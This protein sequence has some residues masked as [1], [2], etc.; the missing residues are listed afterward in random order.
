MFKIGW[1]FSFWSSESLLFSVCFIVFIGL[2]LK[3]LFWGWLQR[4]HATFFWA[5]FLGP[6]TLAW[7]FFTQV[8]AWSFFYATNL[9]SS[10]LRQVCV[11][12]HTFILTLTLWFLFKFHQKCWKWIL[13]S[14]KLEENQRSHPCEIWTKLKFFW[15]F[16][17][18]FIKFW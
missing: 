9:A 6:R 10:S 4:A 5:L 2:F 11:K 12:S 18:D 15:F 14:S 3:M 13:I 7:T 1:I 16:F 17:P 8:L